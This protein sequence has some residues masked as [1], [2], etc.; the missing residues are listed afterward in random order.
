MTIWLLRTHFH[1]HL[2]VCIGTETV[3]VWKEKELL[4][5][6]EDQEICVDQAHMFHHTARHWTP[7]ESNLGE[8]QRRKCCCWRLEGTKRTVIY[9]NVKAQPVQ[10]VLP[11]LGW[12]SSWRPQGIKI[13][14]HLRAIVVTKFLQNDTTAALYGF[15]AMHGL[16]VIL[17]YWFKK[18][19][20]FLYSL[21]ISLPQMWECLSRDTR[22]H[23]WFD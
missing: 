2:T 1:T 22:T 8:E 4:T 19:F 10:C 11:V 21:F 9:I 23:T 20:W 5:Q 16:E 13:S 14:A 18:S 3:K 12:S 17:V 6:T 15:M 7:L